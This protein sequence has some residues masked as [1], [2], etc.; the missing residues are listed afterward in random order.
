MRPSSCCAHSPGSRQVLVKEVSARGEKLAG[1]EAVASRLKDFSRKQDGAV[2][3]S[4]VLTAKER[5]AKVLQRTAERGTA[6]ED[7]RKRAKQVPQPGGACAGASTGLCPQPLTPPHPRAAHFS[8]AS[9]GGC[10]WT[11][12][13]RR[14]RRWRPPASRPR[15]RRR[16]SASWLS[17]R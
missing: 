3:Q 1:L 8:S 10:C 7:A 2:V 5:L 12:W 14:S 9:P 13:T 15:A 11:G 6:L 16:S 4:L 17:T